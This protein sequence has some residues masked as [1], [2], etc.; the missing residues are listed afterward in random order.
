MIDLSAYT[1]NDVSNEYDLQI[2]SELEIVKSEYPF[3]K[4]IPTNIAST[5]YLRTFRVIAVHS[6]VISD[7][8]GFEEDY[9]NEYSKEI[10]LIIPKDY[11][12]N[13][14][15]IYGAKWLNLKD[16]PDN[17]LHIYKNKDNNGYHKLCVGVDGSFINLRYP[18]LESIRTSDKILTAYKLYLEGVTSKVI[19]F[20]YS[21]GEKGKKEYGRDKGKY[22]TK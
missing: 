4:E 17:D 21:H 10:F 14:C 19:L 1:R 18:I 20:A 13:G 8:M 7:E 22:R 9:I 2:N 15:I 11:K 12:V 6:R 3:I 5:S 16:I